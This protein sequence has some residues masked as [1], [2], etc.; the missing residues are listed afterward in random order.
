LSSYQT[1]VAAP[2]RL[3]AIQG[4][5]WLLRRASRRGGPSAPL[6]EIRRATRAPGKPLRQTIAAPWRGDVASTGGLRPSP[7]PTVIGRDSDALGLARP[8]TASAA[9]AN[10]VA[11]AVV[12][13]RSSLNSTSTDATPS[14]AGGCGTTVSYLL[15]VK[16]TVTFKAQRARKGRMRRGKCMKP[17]GHAKGRRCTYYVAI[18]GAFEVAGA[19][20]KDRLKFMG[21]ISNRRLAR[22]RYRLIATPSTAGK[23]GAAVVAFFRIA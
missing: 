15:S 16:A 21:R 12:E 6:G 1:A 18:R 2:E 3:S 8:A 7:R 10:A 23:K 5:A 11:T 9:V 19:A 4:P 17:G 14:V 13:N 20:G 22:G